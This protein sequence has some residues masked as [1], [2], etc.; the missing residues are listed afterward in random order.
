MGKRKTSEVGYG[1]AHPEY[2]PSK[3]YGGAANANAGVEFRMDDTIEGI[4]RMMVG[5]I[6]IEPTIID[7]VSGQAGADT[8]AYNAGKDKVADVEVTWMADLPAA[9]DMPD[10]FFG[11]VKT[12]PNT[13]LTLYKHYAAGDI[14]EADFILGPRGLVDANAEMLGGKVALKYAGRKVET[15]A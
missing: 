12:H 8:R 5:P 13:P 11:L 6:M 15:R 3:D 4:V 14:D 10:D 2:T 7:D 1:W 9:A